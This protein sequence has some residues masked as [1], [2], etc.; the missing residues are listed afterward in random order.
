MKKNAWKPNEAEAALLKA[1]FRR[2]NFPTKEEK[3]SLIKSLEQNLH[4]K[5]EINNLSKWF[6]VHYCL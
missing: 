1:Q 6:K 2:N 4:S 5:V 3:L